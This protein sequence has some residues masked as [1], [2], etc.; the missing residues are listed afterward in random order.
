[1]LDAIPGV[2]LSYLTRPAAAGA[3]DLVI[4]PGTKNTIADLRWLLDSGFKSLLAE[5]L[6]RGGW[7]LGVCGGYQMLGRAVSDPHGTEESGSQSG[8][9]LL[10]VETELDV[11]KVTVQSKG[12]SFLGA[13][14]D[15]YEIHMGRTTCLKAV[16]PF[17][18]KID[19][20]HDGAVSGRVA[21]TY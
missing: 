10:P 16:D 2:T 15:G 9:G 18:T 4:I 11:R 12:C 7:G 8:L 13:A 20:S 6:E 3:L 1:A 17:V 19:G 21:G 5:T 14:V